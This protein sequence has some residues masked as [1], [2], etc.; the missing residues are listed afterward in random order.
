MSSSAV[1]P[2]TLMPEVVAQLNILVDWAGQAQNAS[3][4]GKQAEE[5]C[6]H[7]RAMAIC[8]FVNDGDVDVFFHWLLHAPIT[9]KFYLTMARAE[10]ITESSYERTSFVEPVLDAIAARQWRLA[11]DIGSLTAPEWIDG[12]EYEDD[13]CYGDFLRRIVSQR[14]DGINTLFARWRAVLQGGH[15]ARLDVAE[16]LMAGKLDAF[17]QRLQTLI[18]ESDARARVM[19]NPK[20][21][22]PLASELPFYPNWWV[23]IE[24]LALLAMAKRRG[25]VV[26]D[27]VDA[28]PR[29]VR[30]GSYAPFHPL[31]YP[32]RGIE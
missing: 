2:E 3:D 4:L 14:D 1:T 26:L 10:G 28:C 7:Y 8:L 25:I 21:R 12:V 17:E 5:I 30:S 19:A 13:F 31:G 11:S 6:L 32:N 29:P 23:S 15:D 16:A 27:E 24:G 9:R 18:R 22:S 20:T